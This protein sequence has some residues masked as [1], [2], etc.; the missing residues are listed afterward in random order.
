MRQG[1]KVSDLT[2]KS[3]AKW[4]NRRIY[5]AIY[6]VVNLSVSGGYVLQYAG[7][8]RGSSFISVTLKNF[9]AG[10]F[11]TLPRMYHLSKIFV[12]TRMSPVQHLHL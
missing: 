5:S 2:Y 9:Q 4:K 3:H 8:T 1:Q 7:G 12:N 10:N 11:W 6:G